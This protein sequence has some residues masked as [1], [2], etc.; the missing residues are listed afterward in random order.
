M[1][2]LMSGALVLSLVL[3]SAT[4]FAQEAPTEEPAGPETSTQAETG[5]WLVPAVVGMIIMCALVCGSDEAAPAEEEGEG[6]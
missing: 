3:G 5:K 1:K 4:A 6:E 2:K